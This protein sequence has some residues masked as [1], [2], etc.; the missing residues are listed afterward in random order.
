[1]AYLTLYS[2]NG[3][4]TTYKVDQEIID[5]VADIEL[6]NEIMKQAFSSMSQSMHKNFDFLDKIHN[7]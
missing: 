6:N 4:E 5:Y 3:R 7:N 1:V 2:N